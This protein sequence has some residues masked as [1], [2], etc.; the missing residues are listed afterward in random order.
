M[1]EEL[2]GKL[3]RRVALVSAGLAV[4]VAVVSCVLRLPA[5]ALGFAC[6]VA[7]GLISVGSIIYLVYLVLAPPAGTSV[8]PARRRAAGAILAAGK[9]VLLAAGLYAAVVYLHVNIWALAAGVA[10]PPLLAAFLGLLL[11][12][13]AP[14][15][16]P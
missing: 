10:L 11:P 1:T 5:V 8:S 15:P 16:K 4:L 7:L 6:G 13:T 9:Y 14:S 2:G 3:G 12:A